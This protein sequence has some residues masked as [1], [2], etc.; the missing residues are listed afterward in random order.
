MADS[1]QKQVDSL[2]S[3]IADLRASAIAKQ[4][5]DILST[6][7]AE[8]RIS[9]QMSDQ[10]RADYATA[11]EKL[12]A[13]IAMMPKRNAIPT[14]TPRTDTALENLSW[15]ELD[16]SGQLQKLRTDNPELYRR[17]FFERF[18]TQPNN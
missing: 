15:E 8:H 5:D 14:P 18:G 4:V 7:V 12:Q 1:L 2:N 11:P 9:G 13:L 16:H 17:K 3:E 10:L 6:A